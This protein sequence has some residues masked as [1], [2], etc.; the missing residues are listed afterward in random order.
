[1]TLKV[2]DPGAS[3]RAGEAGGVPSL[4]IMRLH[5]PAEECREK[6]GKD[7]ADYFF[8]VYKDRKPKCISRCE[9]GFSASMN[10]HFGKCMLERSGP[11]C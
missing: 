9:P 7:F 8:V 6:V 11:R 1:M 10:C 2:G 4:L 5:A 3:G